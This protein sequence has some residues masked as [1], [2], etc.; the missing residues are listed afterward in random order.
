MMRVYPE[1][2][3]CQGSKQKLARSTTG[4]SVSAAVRSPGCLEFC[5]LAGRPSRDGSNSRLS[6]L[7]IT[8][9]RLVHSSGG[10]TS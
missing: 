9:P 1:W 6:Y 7:A 8:Y 5:R 4:T 10:A 2:P 3:S